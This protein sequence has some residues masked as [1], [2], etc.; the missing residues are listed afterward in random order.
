MKITS[1]K[2]IEILKEAGHEAYWAGGCVRDMLLGIE[3]KDFDIVTSAKPDEIERLLEHTIPIGKKFGVILAIQDGKSFEIA[4]FRSDSCESDGRRPDAIE[5]TNAKEDALRRDFT[6][7]AMFYDPTQDRILDYVDG[8]R[9]MRDKLIR[10]IGEP[11]QRIQEDY[12]RIL[13]AVRFKNNYD[14]QYH[15]DTYAAIKK[16]SKKVKLISTDRVRD[17]LSKMIMGENAGQ[18]LEELFEIGALDHIIPELCKLKGLAQPLKYHKEGDVWD[19]SRKALD[20]L[21]DEDASPSPL[22]ETPPSLALKWATLMHDIGKYDTFSEERGRIRYDKHAEVGADIAKKIMQRL[23]FPTKVVQ[24]AEWLIAHHMMVVPLLDMTDARRRHWF[25]HPG[26]EELLEI[27]RADAMGIEPMDLSAYR[28]IKQMYKSEIAKLKLMPK[29]LMTGKEI[30]K[31]LGIPQGK[32]IG[33]ILKEIR[34]K[35]LSEE[36]KTKKE[37]KEY[38]KKNFITS[39]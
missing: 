13:R 30:M 29:T 3:P 27:Y 9:D 31:T 32:R 15:P 21:T 24:R 23:K 38:I 25:L 14:M 1:I 22:P 19:H 34:E 26:F 10:F 11:E 35:Q 2:I 7:N 37:A 4:T 5:F 18:A 12:L 28:K 36:I 20:S 16:H 8:E 17:E 39:S 33:E 6:I